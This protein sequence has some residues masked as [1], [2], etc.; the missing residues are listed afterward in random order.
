MENNKMPPGL[1]LIILLMILT[2]LYLLY[3]SYLMPELSIIFS[4]IFGFL[5]ILFIILGVGLLKL[6]N[7][8]RIATMIL[9][10][11]SI[12]IDILI[13]FFS[14]GDFT[15]LVRILISITIVY[16]LRKPKI[17]ILFKPSAI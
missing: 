16:Y 3:Y 6:N 1:I 8:A 11:L 13:S 14:Y 17:K 12:L 15:I 5:G 2:S 7:T 10:T 4:I 9:Y